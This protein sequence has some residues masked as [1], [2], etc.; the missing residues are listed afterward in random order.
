MYGSESELEDSGDE[1][2]NT[3]PSRSTKRKGDVGGARLRIDGDDPMDLLSGAATRVTSTCSMN[4][5]MS[6]MLRLSAIDDAGKKRKKPGQDASRFKTDV[7]SGKMMIDDES[8]EE[9]V[10]MNQDVAGT[11]YRESM[12]SADGF[13]RGPNGRV[14]FNKDTKKRRRDAEGDEDV[15]MADAQSGPAKK[16][17]RR[18]E[19]RLGHEFKAK[20]SPK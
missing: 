14:K 17:K 18:T 13:T 3:A 10:N 8:G 12:T 2:G 16:E 5:L 4:M 6:P 11:A 19:P 1:A 20:V 15:E 9:D 7:E